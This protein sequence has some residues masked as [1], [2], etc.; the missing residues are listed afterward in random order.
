[1]R[2]T[3]AE[4]ARVLAITVGNPAWRRWENSAVR[5]RWGH[6]ESRRSATHPLSYGR[7]ADIRGLCRA[8]VRN[9]SNN[10]ALTPN[11]PPDTELSPSALP[12]EDRDWLPA[13]FHLKGFKL[14]TI[15][16]SRAFPSFLARCQSI[17]L[18]RKD[19]KS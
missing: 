5:V 8:D 11:C 19:A 13:G 2:W 3:T 17:I 10:D 15:L 12:K 6:N 16:L 14:P 1:M 7:R 18:A 4:P 9:V